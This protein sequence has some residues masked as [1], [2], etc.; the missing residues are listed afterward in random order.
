[1]LKKLPESTRLLINSLLPLF[2]VIVLSLIV[3][4]FGLGKISDLRNQI[5]KLQTDQNTLNQKL[6]ILDSLS[7]S[8]SGGSV[9]TVSALPGSNP[10]L[11]S[12]DQIK[13][14]G[15]QNGIIISNIKGG[16]EVKDKSGLLRADVSFD[17]F[18]ARVQI[19]EFAKK[20]NQIAPIT[21]VDKVK[22]TESSG[23]AR[24]SISVRCLWAPYP[25]KLPAVTETITDLT[26]DEK[27]TLGAVNSLIQ[28]QFTEVPPSVNAGKS[29]PFSQ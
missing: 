13:S 11:V 12:L 6:Q 29:D 3:G 26:A 27:K 28:P 25:T 18:G 20:I 16:A 2:G 7:A 24:G 15:V 8:T 23:S 1:M 19:L 14:L 9:A 5:Q 21:L 17:A 22:I 10:V 4:Q